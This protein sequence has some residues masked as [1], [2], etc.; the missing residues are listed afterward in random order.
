MA[1]RCDATCGCPHPCPGGASCKYASDFMNPV[2]SMER[3]TDM[4]APPGNR[5]RP[6]SPAWC[7]TT[8]AATTGTTTAPG[9]GGGSAIAHKFCKCGAHCSCTPCECLTT[10]A[11]G[12][13]RAFC[14]C[15]PGCTC[16]KC[17]T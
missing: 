15:G 9:A 4:P 10:S 12:V 13:G 14:T 8:R 5:Q 17:T 2:N 1:D 16:D 11:G 3:V 6:S 7:T